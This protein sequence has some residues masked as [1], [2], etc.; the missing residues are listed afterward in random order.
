MA[1]LAFLAAAGC[2]GEQ[3]APATPDSGGAVPQ[4]APGSPRAGQ[5]GAC[6]VEQQLCDFALAGEARLRAKD[7]VALIANGHVLANGVTRMLNMLYA[8][9]GVPQLLSIG[10]PV[11]DGGPSC[12]D[13]FAVV[14][15]AVPLEDGTGR[16]IV[17]ATYRRGV[18]PVPVALTFPKVP[19]LS[20]IIEGG[21]ADT[22][23][24]ANEVQSPAD[25]CGEYHFYGQ[26]GTPV[27]PPVV[28]V[29]PPLRDIP[30]A[31]VREMTLGEPY[32]IKPGEV[33]YYTHL[34]DACSAPPIPNLWRAYRNGAGEL[35]VDDLR[36]RLRGLGTVAAFAADWKHGVA[37]VGTCQGPCGP[38]MEG[39]SHR[40]FAETVHKS[41]D[42]GVT[43]R[44]QGVISDATSFL[45]VVGDQVLVADANAVMEGTPRFFFYPSGYVLEVPANLPVLEAWP[46]LV[47]GS[48]VVWR[49]KGGYFDQAGTRLFG[50]QFGQYEPRGLVADHQY[51]HSY[52]TWSERTFAGPWTEQPSYQYVGHI[53][54]DGQMKDAYGLPGDTLWLTGEF[55]RSGDAPPA[56]YGRFRFGEQGGNPAKTSF[57]GVLDL[58][59]AEV[60]PL[61]LPTADAALHQWAYVQGRV[62]VGQP[63]GDT[64][65]VVQ[66]TGTG[67]CLNV[68]GKP[69]LES[70]AF[71]CYVDGVVLGTY[72]SQGRFAGAS[73]LTWSLVITPDGRSGYASAEF[74]R[75]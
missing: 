37:F 19:S 16:G 3:K 24:I 44:E 18:I 60:R 68:R 55:Q 30:G 67:D 47:T 66:V 5:P 28:G 59:T 9:G 41:E 58:A 48:T 26:E 56:L 31:N 38:T 75:P 32:A 1:G 14:Y 64:A 65:G 4:A 73:G 45:G 57:A 71:A 61:S 27:P 51:Q 11:A 17:L 12:R 42:G 10:C 25:G 22:C 50:P 15:G 36:E 54:R 21:N 72:G 6:P 2:S 74:L 49:T 62:Q 7:E 8:T 69:T 40:G 29:L 20:V 34:C 35:V 63:E 70:P 13:R 52:L 23:A 39:G 33:W 46:V 53:D 43:W